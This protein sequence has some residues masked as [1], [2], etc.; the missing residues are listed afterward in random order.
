MMTDAEVMV[1]IH[2]RLY[3]EFQRKLIVG[4]G[5]LHDRNATAAL[6]VRDARWMHDK[7]CAIFPDW[8]KCRS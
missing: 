3:G 7:L 6:I 4:E 5:P 2:A 8:V 1:E